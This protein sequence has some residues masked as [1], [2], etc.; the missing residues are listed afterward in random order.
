VI[1]VEI[2]FNP[3]WWFRNYGIEFDQPFY[4]DRA[5]RIADDVVM[6]R[7]M[8]ERFGLGEAAPQPRPIIG[9]QYVAGGFLI[10]ALFGVEVSFAPHQAPWPVAGARSREEIL[11]LQVPD[12]EGAWPM[13]QWIADMDALEREY[14]HL[15]GDFDLDGVLNTGL[16][17]RGEQIF[18]DLVEDF[19]LTDHLFGVIAE[20]MVRVARYV[21]SRTGTSSVSVNRSILNVNPR[22]YVHGNCSVQM[23]SPASYRQA[24]LK[25]ELYL[26][27]KLAPYGIHHCGN[28]LQRFAKDYAKAKPVFVDV[29]WGSQVAECSA[30]LPETFLNLR[31]SPV[32]MLQQRAAEIRAD[33]QGLL[34]ASGRTRN[35]GLCCINMD[36]GTPE[37]NVLAMLD[38]ARSAP[39]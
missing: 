38:V 25:H 18:L 10:P 32:R 6:R 19:E 14:G 26:A 27:E 3:H 4:L 2:V 13:R 9:S 22:A 35:V 28:N 29:G 31:M 5:R 1:P 7:A 24:L 23:I 36:Y 17:L 12:I 39:D 34:A 15:V 11:A 21:T 33:A 37:E 20:T 30:A 8:Y 16:L